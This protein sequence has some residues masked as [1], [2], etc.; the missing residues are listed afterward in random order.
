MRCKDWFVVVG[1]GRDE[2]DL[3][4][5]W[6]VMV[7]KCDFCYRIIFFIL[8]ICVCWVWLSSTIFPAPLSTF[9][10]VKLCAFLE[11]SLYNVHMSS[12]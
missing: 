1:S 8:Y 12:V 6:D 2:W 5:G 3:V 7:V 11:A 10:S 4:E 9:C